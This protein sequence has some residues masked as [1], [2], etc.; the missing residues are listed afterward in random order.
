MM[1]L[2]VSCS[3]APVVRTLPG[4]GGQLRRHL[5]EQESTLRA[6]RVIRGLDDAGKIVACF[7][8]ATWRRM[9]FRGVQHGTGSPGRAYS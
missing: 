3:S 9:L 6:L 4:P 5:K 8:P 1:L 7:P 2:R